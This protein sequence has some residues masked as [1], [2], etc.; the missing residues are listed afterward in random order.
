[1]DRLKTTLLTA[2]VIAILLLTPAASA[3]PV[4]ANITVVSG[5]GQMICPSCGYGHTV[6]PFYPMVVKVTDASGKPIANK[7]VNWLSWLVTRHQRAL[8]GGFKRNICLSFI[9][10][11]EFW[12]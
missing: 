8:Y 4:A 3:Q 5:N 12:G 10:T 11:G 1:M 2:F 6:A 9:L 7:T